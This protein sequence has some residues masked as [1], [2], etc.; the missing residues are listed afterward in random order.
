MTL[1]TFVM[2]PGPTEM[3]L[4]VL[5]ALMKPAITPGDPEFMKVCDDTAER[6]QTILGTTTV[7]LTSRTLAASNVFLECSVN[8]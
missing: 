1:S 7:R 3:P 5:K 4:R 2:T 6:L 8:R